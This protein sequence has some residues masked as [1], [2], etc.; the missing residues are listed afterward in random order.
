MKI[1]SSEM[2]RIHL[3]YMQNSVSQSEKLLVNYSRTTRTAEAKET[4]SIRIK[5]KLKEKQDLVSINIK[6]KEFY[7]AKE[8]YSELPELRLDR[9]EEAEERLTSGTYASSEEIAKQIV[10]RSLID[11][12]V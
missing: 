1:S 2:E 6:T 10:L 3:S 5:T 9:I 8:L 12:E 7:K 11:G 4:D